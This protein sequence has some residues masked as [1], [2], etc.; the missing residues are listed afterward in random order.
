MWAANGDKLLSASKES[1]CGSIAEWNKQ[2]LSRQFPYVTFILCISTFIVSLAVNDTI[3]GTLAGQIKVPELEPYGG[4]TLEHLLNFELWRLLVSQ[5]IHVKQF[6]MFYNVLSL[7]VLGCLLETRMSRFVFVSIWFLAGSAGTF[8][9]TFTVPAPWNLGT[10]G[11]Q[12]ILALA[13]AGVVLY[14]SGQLRTKITAFV[15][16]WVIFPAFVLDIIY[17]ENHLPKPGHIVS[18]ALGLLIA[19]FYVRKSV[20][21]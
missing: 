4:Y 6:H 20:T 3:S 8:V 17:A 15:L 10:G 14:A 21:R 16:G 5:F 7:F 13:A 18:F 11:S 1:A 12:G 19:L 2:M 9:S